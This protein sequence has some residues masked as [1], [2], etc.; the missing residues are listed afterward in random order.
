MSHF[1]VRELGPLHRSQKK[2]DVMKWVWGVV[3]GLGTLL[4]SPATGTEVFVTIDGIT[5]EST[6]KG[7]EG[8]IAA[9]HF[10]ETWRSGTGS[11]TG[12]GGGAG[13]PT[14]GPVVFSK[15]LGASS[16]QLIQALV[17]GKILT[18]VTLEFYEGHDGAQQATYK[19]TLTE[20]Q[21][22]AINQKTIEGGRVVD[23]VQI[24]F[25]KARW[26]TFSPAT[27]ATFDTVTGKSSTAKPATTK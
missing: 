7:H 12:G 23:E 8:Q 24:S 26:E 13:K 9:F 15:E 25:R 6:Q 10:S 3:L 27:V 17:D 2:G 20:A 22:A 11:T 16:V 18:S 4:G 1:W 5:G 14:L 21:V 19:I